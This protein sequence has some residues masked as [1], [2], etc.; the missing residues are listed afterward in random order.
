MFRYIHLDFGQTILISFWR[1]SLKFYIKDF[2]AFETASRKA[3]F[4]LLVMMLVIYTIIVSFTP[5]PKWI[6]ILDFPSSVEITALSIA[7]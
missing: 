7:I 4:A 6:D 1:G 2:I 3:N 5:P